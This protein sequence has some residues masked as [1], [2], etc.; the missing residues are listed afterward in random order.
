MSNFVEFSFAETKHTHTHCETLA[1]MKACFVFNLEML[2]F[3]TLRFRAY[4]LVTVHLWRLIC[5]II[6]STA[7]VL[8]Q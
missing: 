4:L 7:D 5:H 2:D 6:V 1:M 3:F 8:Q